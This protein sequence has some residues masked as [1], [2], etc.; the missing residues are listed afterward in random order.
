MVGPTPSTDPRPDRHRPTNIGTGGHG[1]VSGYGV[2][3]T[4]EPGRFRLELRHGGLEPRRVRR[5]L[6]PSIGPFADLLTMDC[7][8]ATRSES[9]D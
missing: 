4:P 8:A 1:H 5:A 6:P 3:G 2:R 9:N 7:Q